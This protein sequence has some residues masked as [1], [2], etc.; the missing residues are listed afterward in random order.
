MCWG[1]T[2]RCFAATAAID[3]QTDA[4]LVAA[5]REYTKRSS[6]TDRQPQIWLLR[7]A[8]R[9]CCNRE[10]ERYGT[11]SHMFK[12]C[13]ARPAT[14]GRPAAMCA[15][16]RQEHSR[17][18]KGVLRHAARG[19]PLVPLLCSS[20]VSCAAAPPVHVCTPHSEFACLVAGRQGAECLLLRPRGGG[21]HVV[22]AAGRAAHDGQDN[23]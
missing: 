18:R 14:S 7:I 21:D 10:H 11:W 13:L 4:C 20:S 9:A 1:R 17:G 2:S 23:A 15:D 19:V 12:A 16:A 6:S 3:G 22:A 8:L 5:M